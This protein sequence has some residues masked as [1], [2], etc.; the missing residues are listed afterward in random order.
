M[1]STSLPALRDRSVKVQPPLLVK[2]WGGGGCFQTLGWKV[3]KT[4]TLG[5][6]GLL[7][8]GGAGGCEIRPIGLRGRHEGLPLLGPWK[9]GT[10]ESGESLFDTLDTRLAAERMDAN[11]RMKRKITGDSREES[12]GRRLRSANRFAEKLAS[13]IEKRNL[14]Q[15]SWER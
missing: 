6:S 11:S 13:Q 4:Q 8:L 12:S 14:G 15:D 9:D 3:D 2:H 7:P 1:A 5:V 10:P